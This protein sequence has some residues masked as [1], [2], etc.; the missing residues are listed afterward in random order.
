MVRS[1]IAEQKSKQAWSV[2]SGLATRF[3]RTRQRDLCLVTGDLGT[4]YLEGP[5]RDRGACDAALEGT[6]ICP[7]E[8][9]AVWSQRAAEAAAAGRGTMP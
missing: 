3:G 2:Y 9:L 4:T 1:G 6:H 8:L 5:G 7:D